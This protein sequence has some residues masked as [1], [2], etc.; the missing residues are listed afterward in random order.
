MMLGM[1]RLGFVSLHLFFSPDLVADRKSIARV[2]IVAPTYLRRWTLP[3]EK[4]FLIIVC[5][6]DGSVFSTVAAS[7]AL[8]CDG[9]EA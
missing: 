6:V 7:A 3:S 2:F 5:D 9:T 8:S 1:E 4:S